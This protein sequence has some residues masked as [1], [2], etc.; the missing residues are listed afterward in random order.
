[1]PLSS[2]DVKRVADEVMKRLKETDVVTYAYV[3]ADGS[4]KSKTVSVTEALGSAA[5]SAGRANYNA[6][7]D[8]QK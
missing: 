7:H 4:E 6:K 5:S 8:D 3:N 1:M 2:D